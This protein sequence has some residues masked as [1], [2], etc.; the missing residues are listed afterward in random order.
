MTT[1]APAPAEPTPIKLTDEIKEAVNNALAEQKPVMIAYVD[2]DGQP[3]LSFRGST[4]VESDTQLGIWVRREDGGLLK[5]L[6]K[7][8]RIT[9]F[10]RNPETRAMI[11]FRGR[12][13]VENTEQMRNEMY[14]KIPQQERSA[15]PQQKGIPLVIDLDRVDG[16][17]P[18]QRIMM[19]RM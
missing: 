17:M 14:E 9:L 1:P 18:G 3:S 15:D 10:Y 19:R 7:N 11:Q 13:R 5:A 12:G 2:P 8:P 16:F 6:Q 4:H